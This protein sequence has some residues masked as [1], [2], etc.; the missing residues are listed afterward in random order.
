MW[1]INQ[2]DANLLIYKKQSMKTLLVNNSTIQL[3]YRKKKPDK[4]ANFKDAHINQQV[5]I[6]AARKNL[7]AYYW[8]NLAIFSPALK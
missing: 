7:L 8:H 4:Q 3:S 2:H 6:I 5:I 1:F